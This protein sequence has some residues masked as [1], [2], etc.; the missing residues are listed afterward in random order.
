MGENLK[1]NGEEY[2]G[3]KDMKISV[4]LCSYNGEKY[5]EQQ[6]NSIL[7]QS[8]SIDEIIVCDDGSTDNTVDIVKRVLSEASVSYRIEI[9]EQSLGV[10][11]NF[12]KALKL[13][14]G[15]YVFTCDQDD[16]WNIDKVKTFLCEAERTK[17]DLYFSNGNLIDS[18]G[19]A[20]GNTLWEAY[21]IYYNV[22]IRSSLIHT[23]VK[24]TL[25]TGAAMMVSRELIDMINSIPENW[26]HDEWFAIVAALKNS[27]QP[28]NSLTF[29]YRQHGKN[30]VGAKKRT[31]LEKMNVWLSNYKNLNQ[32]R[33]NNYARS[34]A[35]SS[36][37]QN[38]EY[39]EITTRSRQFW[40]TLVNLP[41]L[42]RI[43]GFFV[44][45]K[46]FLRGEYSVFYTGIR[47]FIRDI[48]SVLFF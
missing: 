36:V 30:V 7:N 40:E 17:K 34:C 22:I 28:I 24:K 44:V 11:K 5:I 47:G 37:A 2:G 12:L 25:A 14:T 6:L 13:T 48:I 46:M 16:V 31:F 20:L 45:L 3:I 39:A 32:I 41:N 18:D 23:L 35:V 15:Q 21:G 43:K 4:A 1:S 26:L 9:N 38:T 29:D 19:N 27:M 8:V 10:A 33:G 42:S